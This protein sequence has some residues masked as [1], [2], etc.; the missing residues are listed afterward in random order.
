MTSATILIP[1][2]NEAAVIGRTLLYLF[3]GPPART[4]PHHRHRQRM[5]RRDGGAGPRGAAAGRGDRDRARGQVPRAEPRLSRGRSR[6]ADRLSRRGSRSH[7]GGPR[8][9]AGAP[10]R[11]AR[12]R[13]PAAR[14]TWKPPA[15]RRPSGSSTRAGGPTPISPKASSVASSRCRPMGR[16]GSFRCPTSQ[17]MT[18]TSAGVFAPHEIAFVPG[19]R[20]VARAPRTLA[21]LLQVRPPQAS[22]A[23][24]TWPACGKA[25][26]ERGS[27]LA[28]C[29]AA[30]S[31]RLPKR[32]RSPFFSCCSRSG[33]ACRF[34]STAAR[35]AGN[36]T[37]RPA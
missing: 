20:F 22:G 21:S 2:H 30:P 5:H 23:R 25:S 12:L 34:C 3:A 37:P 8:V 36:A 29:C 16:H 6:R 27:A 9:T 14:W 24:A 10:C 7:G 17:R 28:D 1:A 11:T 35:L 13:R 15:S 31:S 32:F 26:P 33:C 4:V 19:C 18:N